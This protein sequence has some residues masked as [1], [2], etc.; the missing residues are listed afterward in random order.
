MSNFVCWHSPIQG[1]GF[2]DQNFE[3]KYNIVSQTASSGEVHGSIIEKVELYDT[4]SETLR[5]NFLPL[6]DSL[7]VRA[8]L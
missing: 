5:I 6:F 7:L 4:L 1:S 2:E 8:Q 3:P